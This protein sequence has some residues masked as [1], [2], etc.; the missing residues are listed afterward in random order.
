MDQKHVHSILA[1]EER[2]TRSHPQPSTH[3]RQIAQLPIKGG[4]QVPT[5]TLKTGAV[6]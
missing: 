1:V 2:K 3:T 4:L 6:G 5:A